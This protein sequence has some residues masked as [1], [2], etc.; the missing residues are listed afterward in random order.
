MSSSSSGGSEPADAA[1]SLELDDSKEKSCVYQ[2]EYPYFDVADYT[3][4]IE[5]SII[6]TSSQRKSSYMHVVSNLI[7]L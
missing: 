1:T 2:D 7:Q 6:C 4:A 5:G 3:C